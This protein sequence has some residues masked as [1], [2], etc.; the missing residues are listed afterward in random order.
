MASRQRQ[1]PQFHTYRDVGPDPA[2]SIKMYKVHITKWEL[3]KRN[4]EHEVLAMAR[5]KR[6]RDAVGKR[7]EFRIRGRIVSI[8]DVHR[9]LKRKGMSVEDAIARRAATPPNLRCCTPESVP[10][11]PADPKTFEVHRRI[12]VSVRNHVFGSVESKTWFLCRDDNCFASG[13]GMVATV[14]DTCM[15]S[16]LN[17]YNY[18]VIGSFQKAGNFLVRGSAFIRDVLLEEY[19]RMLNRLFEVLVVLRKGGWIDCSKIILNQFSEMAATVLIEMHPLRTIFKCLISCDPELA[20]DLLTSVW[21]SYADIFEQTFGSSS[22]ASIRNRADYI[23]WIVRNRDAN[24]AEAQLR[25]LVKKCE[26]AHG[27]LDPRYMEALLTL[28]DFL[29]TERQTRDAATVAEV[30]INCASESKSA[31]AIRFW[32]DGMELLARCQYENLDDKL[33]ELNLRQAVD[34]RAT[35]WGWQNSYTLILLTTLELWLTEFG[36]HGEAVKVSEQIAEISRQS[37]FFV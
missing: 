17:A 7:S 22:L 28:S 1:A 6:Q 29:F 15:F 37:N 21:E 10:R 9:Y 5:K 31:H 20:A 13:K 12:L 23:Y 19:P 35:T 11:S 33:A 16:F 25:S 30:L 2:I 32:C 18:L 3:D 24:I 36:K 8:E 26:E 27:N 4:K 14:S 34:M